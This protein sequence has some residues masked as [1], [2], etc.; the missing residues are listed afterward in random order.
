MTTLSYR[1]SI[2]VWMI[3]AFTM[4]GIMIFAASAADDPGVIA[5]S[6][7]PAPPPLKHYYPTTGV[8]PEI[9][10]AENLLA[11]SSAPEPA[12]TYRRNY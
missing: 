9:G 10:R 3:I 8:K 11:P 5:R 7:R 1:V 4:F 2:T 12:K 6:Y